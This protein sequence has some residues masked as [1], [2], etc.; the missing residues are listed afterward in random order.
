MVDDLMQQRALPWLAGMGR[1]AMLN[2][3]GVPR[4]GA[5]LS[6]H[7]AA[8][9]VTGSCYALETSEARILI[10][11]GMFQGSK[12]EKELNYRPFP[13][14]PA[15]LDA[16]LLTHAHIDHS[17]L[18]P[19]LAKDGFGGPIFAT[20]A[21]IDLCSVMLPDAGHIQEMEVAQLNRRN[22][23]RGL[24][25]VQPIYDAAQAGVTMTQFRPVSF[26]AW[27]PVAKGVKARYWN[28]GH[29][30]GSASI[31][32]EV[33]THADKPLRL[34]FS[35][36]IGPAHKLLQSGP[37]APRDLDYVICESTYGD[38]D[39]QDASAERRLE[40]LEAEVDGA[41]KAAGALLIPS[42]AVERT[43]ELLV[44]LVQL[45]E[46]GRVPSAPI[47]VDSPLATR[48]SAVFE[49]HAGDI[50]NGEALRQALRAPQVRFTE[51]VE[52]SKAIARI[53]GFHIVIAASGMCEAGRIRHHLK[54]WLWREAATILFVGFQAQGTLGRILLDGASRVRLMGEDVQVRARI[55][56]VDLYSGHADGPELATWLAGRGAVFGAVFLTHGETHA[57]DGL[58][59]RLLHTKSSLRIVTPTLDSIFTLEGD[60]LHRLEGPV[61][62]A[63]DSAGRRDW[64]NELSNLILDIDEAV[65]QAADERARKQI[66]RRLRKALVEEREGPG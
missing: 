54:E 29:L 11:C 22:S 34:L 25:A 50:G 10:D 56:S 3:E 44:D 9:A 66:I 63:P 8:Q 51:S 32:L 21:T 18:L 17:G 31:E 7:G 24:P 33:D 23:R 30:L 6:F 27:T 47:F 39:R 48:A 64:H 2:G 36:D 12:T 38:V 65:A 55:R 35:G 41:A 40:I 62:L 49:K 16:V 13:F 37:T 43:Q 15:S 26:G 58:E 4:A 53:R 19:K 1:T 45:M 5:R 61:R 59:E 57:I 42:F 28:A 60:T 46:S 52:Q 20:S 14:N